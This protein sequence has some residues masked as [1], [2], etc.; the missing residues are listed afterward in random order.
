MDLFSVV[1]RTLKPFQRGYFLNDD[2][3][4]YPYRSSTVKGIYLYTATPTITLLVT[5][6]K[7]IPLIIISLYKFIFLL[8]FGYTVVSMF[9]NMGKVFVG[10]LRPYFHDVCGPTVITETPYGYI[11]EFTCTKN[12]SASIKK[13]R[14][15]FPSG[16]V[17][18]HYRMPDIGLGSLLQAFVP[19]AALTTAFYVGITRI[20]DYKHHWTDV[21]GGMI[22]GALVGIFTVSFSLKTLDQSFTGIFLSYSHAEVVV[23]I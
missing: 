5:R 3:L 2:S 13:M 14:L 22:I 11:S 9:V 20:S 19:T 4:K 8:V 18:L 23:E 17:Y 16:H 21:L 1:I 7:N 10:R 15:S 6:Y 12:G